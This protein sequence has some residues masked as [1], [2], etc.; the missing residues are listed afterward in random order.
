MTLRSIDLT[1]ISLGWKE[2]RHRLG[3]PRLAVMEKDRAI[4][5]RF[6]VLSRPFGTEL[7]IEGQSVRLA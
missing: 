3:L 2:A 6:A 7:C 4:L 5:D 1:P